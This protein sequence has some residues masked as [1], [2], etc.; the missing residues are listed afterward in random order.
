MAKLTR[1]Q[2]NEIF[3]IIADL[4]RAKGYLLDSKTAICRRR[5]MATTTLDYM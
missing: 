3:R 1:Q 2:Q 5:D 4:G